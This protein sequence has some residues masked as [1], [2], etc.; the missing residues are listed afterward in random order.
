MSC[1][2]CKSNAL[3]ICAS[4]DEDKLPVKCQPFVQG[5]ENYCF[6]HVHNETI[7]RGC[8]LETESLMSD[9][10]SMNT[11]ICIECRSNNCN[12]QTISNEYCYECDSAVN[13]NCTSNLENGMSKKC[14]LNVYR[15]G[16]Y[17]IE[18]NDGKLLMF[19]VFFL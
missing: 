5:Y 8:I 17:R 19:F 9:C 10:N 14:P 12:R 7:T 1:V 13:P 2:K 11:E 16:C 18:D 6:T 4:I 3:G 15:R